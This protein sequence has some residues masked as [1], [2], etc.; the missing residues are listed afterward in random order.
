M[1]IIISESSHHA[2][3][4]DS[5]VLTEDRINQLMNMDIAFN[6]RKADSFVLTDDHIKKIVRKNGT[7]V[8]FF[9][10]GLSDDD[11][12]KLRDSHVIDLL[13]NPDHVD[14][15]KVAFIFLSYCKGI[16]DDFGIHRQ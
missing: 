15:L 10:I 8:D 13:S 14:K 4:A 16:T 7:S 1:D 11:R 9:L 3:E 5:F 6:N 12:Q 2:S